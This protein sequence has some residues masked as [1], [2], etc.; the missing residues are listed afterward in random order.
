MGSNLNL[1]APFFDS[2]K[3]QPDGLAIWADGREHT[4][5]EARS[6]VQNVANWLQK[7]GGGPP[8]YVGILA[9]RSW[10]ACVGILGAACSG[11][12][13]V[14]LNISQPA[15]ALGQLLRGI[16]LDALIVDRVGAHLL[17]PEVLEHAPRKILVPAGSD[18][19][20]KSG[21]SIQTFETLETDCNCEPQS[22]AAED[23][24]YVEFTSGSTGTPKA[25][26]IPNGAVAHFLR[27]MQRRYIFQ[28]GDR[29]A[30]TAETSFDISVFNMFMSWTAGASLHVV[31]KT[32]ALAPAKFIRDHAISVWF[33]VPSGAAAMSRMNLLSPGAFP[34]LR[35]SLFSGEPLPAKVAMAWK[36]AA[37]NSV[38]DNLYGPT[39]ATVI[40][41]YERVGETANVTKGKRHR[42][43]RETT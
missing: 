38:V 7:T 18:L 9:S 15:G 12:A 10:E 24:A 21:H 34:S 23:P 17:T 14:A 30:E 42:R 5:R 2:A 43:H 13:Y 28:P 33:S 11:A 4:Y 19:P 32:Q 31:P 8:R 27:V 29:I 40:C 6:A 16:Q 26:I 37:P 1:A 3:R 25:V 41:L 20:E 35:V 36:K 39:E 22:V